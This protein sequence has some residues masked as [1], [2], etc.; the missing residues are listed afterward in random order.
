MLEMAKEQSEVREVAAALPKELWPL[1][2]V[3]S[4][5]EQLLR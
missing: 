5:M 4:T 3:N 2:C 1:S